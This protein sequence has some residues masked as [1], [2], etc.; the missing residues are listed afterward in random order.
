MHLLFQTLQVL[1]S[2][3]T[4][5]R[6]LTCVQQCCAARNTDFRFGRTVMSFLEKRYAEDSAG[7][8]PDNPHKVKFAHSSNVD[9]DAWVAQQAARLDVD[10]VVYDDFQ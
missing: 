4:T 10:F 1:V 6:Y 7:V 2:G 9:I 3:L 5:R 8:T